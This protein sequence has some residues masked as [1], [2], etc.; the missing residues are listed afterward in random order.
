MPQSLSAPARGIGAPRPRTA[1]WLALG[2]AA[3]LAGLW[4]GPLPAL[5]GDAF[6]WHMVL[7]VGLL[8]LAAPVL[9]F[10][11]L[12]AGWRLPGSSVWLWAALGATVF[13]LIVVWSWHA[14]GLHAAAARV[15]AVFALQQ[16]TF[17]L[18]G[19]AVWVASF[20][21]PSRLGALVGAGAMGMSFM[22]MSM[23][24]VVLAT[25]SRLIYPPELCGSSLSLGALDDQRLGGVLMATAGALPYLAGSLVLA[26]RALRDGATPDDRV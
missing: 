1:G 12:Q 24:G 26:A 8:A 23:L 15:P 7:H 21:V 3:I 2:G 16:A 14:P 22:H 10:A 18:A 19:M 17:L 6:T 13:D 4:G 9:S 5:A 20:S 25:T 11:L